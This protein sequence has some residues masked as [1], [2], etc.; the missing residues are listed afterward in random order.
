MKNYSNMIHALFELMDVNGDG[1]LQEDEYH[2]IHLQLGM[3]EAPYAKETFRAIDVNH[4]GK[5]SF[6]EI[7]KP[8]STSCSLRMNRVRIGT[9]LGLSSTRSRAQRIVNRLSLFPKA[10]CFPPKGL[11][12]YCYLQYI[13]DGQTISFLELS[14]VLCFLRKSIFSALFYSLTELKQYANKLKLQRSFLQLN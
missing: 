7:I 3:P 1:Y 14:S 13:N 2:R 5:L 11:L 8:S 12:N 10:L 6:D 4:D 9:S